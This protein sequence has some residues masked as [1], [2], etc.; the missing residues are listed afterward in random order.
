MCLDNKKLL[1][2]ETD[3]T[4]NPWMYYRLP[5]SNMGKKSFD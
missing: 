3:T 5:K 4:T 1:S 2:L